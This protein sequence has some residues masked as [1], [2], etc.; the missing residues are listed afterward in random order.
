MESFM[1]KIQQC[2]AVL[3]LTLVGL[4]G[5]DQ[6]S[7]AVEAANPVRVAEMQRT[8][9]ELWLGHIFSVQH[10]V[11]YTAKKDPMELDAAEKEVVTNAKQIASAFTP[12]YGEARSEKLFTLLT[13]H[14][15]AVK[16]Y[17]AATIAGN[18]RQ[19]NAALAHFESNTDDIA[20]FFNGVN[21]QYLPKDTI[22]GLIAAHVAHHILRIN[23]YKKRN[24]AQLDAT[25][26]I[27]RQHVYVIAD[28]L[29]TALAKQFPD[30]F[31]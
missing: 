22:R 11:L 5:F 4:V 18:T 13:G 10:V 28:T 19:Q 3:A 20:V 26:P 2:M 31:S 23:L 30:K 7:R 17:S 8:L 16:E 29:A 12:Y 15:A 9:R 24:Y 27:M 25:W 1:S 14:Y 21:P 6:E